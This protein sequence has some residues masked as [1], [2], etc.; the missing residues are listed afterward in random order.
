MPV[1]CSGGNGTRIEKTKKTVETLWVCSFDYRE[2]AC[3]VFF[4]ETMHV[5]VRVW[6]QPTAECS[7]AGDTPKATLA[8]GSTC[9]VWMVQCYWILQ[10]AWFF[11]FLSKKRKK[12]ACNAVRDRSPEH[13]QLR[14]THQEEVAQGVA[15]ASRTPRHATWVCQG[16]ARRAC[17]RTKFWVVA[18]TKERGNAIHYACLNTAS[19]RLLRDT[20]PR[21]G[22]GRASRLGCRQKQNAPRVWGCTVVYGCMYVA[23]GCCCG[24]LL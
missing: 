9:F 6:P 21:R 17:R 13:N 10:A 14:V 7:A 16:A 20:V 24:T 3:F 1:C 2:R 23:L 15:V 4:N 5:V 8:S 22:C 11:V 18:V 19:S 12:N